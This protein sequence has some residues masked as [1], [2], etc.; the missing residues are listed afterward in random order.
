[1]SN[2][3]RSLL[4]AIMCVFMHFFMMKAYGTEGVRQG[5]L[6]LSVSISSLHRFYV[7]IIINNLV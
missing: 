4:T 5:I 6:K 3:R 7:N 1:M 2:C